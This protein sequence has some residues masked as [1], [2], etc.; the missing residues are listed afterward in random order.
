[1]ARK[2]FYGDRLKCARKL[3]AMT[4]TALAAETGISKQ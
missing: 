4:L 3:R 2:E 1:M